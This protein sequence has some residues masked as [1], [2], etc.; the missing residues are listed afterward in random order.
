MFRRVRPLEEPG[1]NSHR[2]VWTRFMKRVVPH[3][4]ASTNPMWTVGTLSPFLLTLLRGLRSSYQHGELETGS[5][6]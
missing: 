1:R 2:S 4:Q 3:L 5:A 6:S